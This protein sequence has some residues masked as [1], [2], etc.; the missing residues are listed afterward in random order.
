MR[1]KAIAPPDSTRR[2]MLAFA[3]LAP[4]L[5]LPGVALAQTGAGDTLPADLDEAVRAYHRATVAGDIDT[6]GGL[7]TDDYLL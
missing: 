2:F 1:S 7:V 5:A 3:T 4:G 6:L